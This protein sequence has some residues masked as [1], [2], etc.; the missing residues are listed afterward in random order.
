MFLQYIIYRSNYHCHSD[1][2]YYSLWEEINNKNF[3]FLG[4][5]RIKNG[6][7]KK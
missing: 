5:L 1:N 7:I 2:F 4:S 3:N 6:N